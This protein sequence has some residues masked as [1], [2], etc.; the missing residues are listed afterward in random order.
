M[1]RHIADAGLS[2]SVH[3]VTGGTAQLNLQGPD[4]RALLQRVTAADL[5]DAAFPFRT[6]RTVEIGMAVRGRVVWLSQWPPRRRPRA[7]AAPPH[8]TPPSWQ[9]SHASR[10]WASSVTRSSSRPNSPPTCTTSS[11]R[12]PP[13]LPT[14]AYERSGLSAWRR[15]A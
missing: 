15:G 9:P 11:S 6:A 12:P 4:A 3:D 7:A 5:G 13:A 1:R 8:P 14:S 2:A 10:T